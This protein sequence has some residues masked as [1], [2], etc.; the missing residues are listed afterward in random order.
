M[1]EHEWGHGWDDPHAIIGW[2]CPLHAPLQTFATSQTAEIIG[3]IN[4][5]L[6]VVE[7]ALLLSI[8]VGAIGLY[9]L[10]SIALRWVKAI[11]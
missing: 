6:P 10:A 1:P 2:G 3:G 5:F 11:S 4:Y 8:W 7:M 9:Y